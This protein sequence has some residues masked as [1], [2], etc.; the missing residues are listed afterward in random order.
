MDTEPLDY[1]PHVLREYAFLGDGHRGALCDPRGNIAWLCAPRWND[2]AVCSTLV[3]G[4]GSYAVTP[5]ERYV[6]GGSYEPGTLIWRNRWVTSTNSVIESREALAYPGEQDRLLL[7]RRI[8]ALDHDAKVEVVLDLRSDFGRLSMRQLH[9]DEDG[10]WTAR[11][12][13]LYV[14]WTGARPGAP[15]QGR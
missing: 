12:G 2:P 9:R 8:G 4:R 6:W 13:D 1:P 7:L 14:R 15:P 3:G 5:K 10:V 11:T